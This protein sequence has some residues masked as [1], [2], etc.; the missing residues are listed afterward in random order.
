MGEVA[1]SM[2]QVLRA[3]AGSG[4]SVATL[5]VQHG[6]SAYSVFAWTDVE[7]RV[8]VDIGPLS[9]VLRVSP[10]AMFEVFLRASGEYTLTASLDVDCLSGWGWLTFDPS[11]RYPGHPLPGMPRPACAAPTG[12]PTDPAVL[13]EVRQLAGEFAQRYTLI[14]G[15]APAWSPAKTEQELAAAEAHIGARLPE[16]LRALYR[17]TGRDV[18]ETGLLGRYSH[19]DL[20]RLVK[21]YLEGGPGSYGWED[22]LSE[23][24]VVF[25]ITPVGR[26][27]RVSRN[28]WWVTF[29][30]DHEGNF[31]AVDL[32]PAEQGRSG[33]VIEYGRDIQGPLRYVSASIMD[34]LTEVVAALRAGRYD[35]DPHNPRLGPEVGF[36]HDDKRDYREIINNVGELDLRAEVAAF[37]DPQ[38][39]QEVSVG[40]TGHHDLAVFEALPSLRSLGIAA[41]TVLPTVSGLRALESLGVHARAMDLTLLAGHPLLWNLSLHGMAHP[42][43]LRPLHALPRLTR[44]TLAGL[45]IPELERIGELAGVRVLTLDLQQL[46]R[47]VDAGVSLETLAALEITEPMRLPELVDLG[48]RLQHGKTAI[49]L[50]Q[51]SGTLS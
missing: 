3:G 2:A 6:G 11:F 51:T 33:Q 39:I 23:D 19:D 4:W 31:L 8:W 48:R 27:K 44:L 47:L 17:V 29:G 34:M 40:Y 25:E 10:P 5:Q 9:P 42:I 46:R 38:L 16:D 37:A 50:F 36:N 12:A 7:A 26:V 32:D 41:D 22:G 24:G 20:D 45:D 43:D 21:R 15:H 35:E 14:K 30:S 1:K 13:A 18:D 28:D 49:Q